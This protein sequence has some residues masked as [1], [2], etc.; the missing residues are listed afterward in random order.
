M[1]YQLTDREVE[2]GVVE[3]DF[4]LFVIDARILGEMGTIARVAADLSWGPDLPRK[5]K[6]IGR[7]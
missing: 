5:Y 3:E 6:G 1:V 7:G 4:D 2:W